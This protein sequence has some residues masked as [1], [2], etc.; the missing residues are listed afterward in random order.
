M[1][2]MQLRD[3]ETGYI[4][5]I[6]PIATQGKRWFLKSILTACGVSAGQDGIYS[7]DIKDVV[8]KEVNGL[9]EHE[10]NSYI[11]REG[12]TIEEMQHKIVEVQELEWDHDK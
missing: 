2:I 9:V 3:K 4:D 12:K 7:W 10:P 6:Y 1:F 5:K 11:N 8:G